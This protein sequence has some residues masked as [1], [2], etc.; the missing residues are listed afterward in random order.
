MI[1]YITSILSI[2]FVVSK[3]YPLCKTITT[4]AYAEANSIC[5]IECNGMGY[6]CSERLHALF[7]PEGSGSAVYHYETSKDCGSKTEAKRAYYCHHQKSSKVPPALHIRRRRKSEPEIREIPA[8]FVERRASGPYSRHKEDSPPTVPIV[9]VPPGVCVLS[10]IKYEHLEDYH[11]HDTWVSFYGEEPDYYNDPELVHDALCFSSNYE[12]C[13][14]AFY[15]TKE[16]LKLL[17]ITYI[18]N[19]DE[20]NAIVLH[21]ATQLTKWLLAYIDDVQPDL[22]VKGS[23]VGLGQ[24]KEAVL[25]VAYQG[26]EVKA[27]PGYKPDPEL[28]KLKTELKEKY[29][30]ATNPDYRMAALAC[31]IAE[32]KAIEVHGWMRLSEKARITAGDEIFLCPGN[33]DKLA[34]DCGASPQCNRGTPGELSSDGKK[35]T[36][37]SGKLVP[38]YD[39]CVAKETREDCKLKDESVVAARAAPAHSQYYNA[40]NAMRYHDNDEEYNE[41]VG[42]YK[43]GYVKG[44]EDAFARI[45]RI[46]GAQKRPMV[47]IR[48][49]HYV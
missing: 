6:S 1:P 20:D 45:K 41:H 12:Q 33:K 40:L 43:A 28:T 3:A 30:T 21:E 19:N 35:F 38:R 17:Y 5:K 42:I 31:H 32:T 18:I 39:F 34:L 48:H 10:G 44:Y 26:D 22:E 2:L 25:E 37:D 15:K 47:H 4:R 14:F 27:S 13:G 7:G 49:K 46:P 29:A 36:D 16:P 8:L 23:K 24:L 9:S 11:K